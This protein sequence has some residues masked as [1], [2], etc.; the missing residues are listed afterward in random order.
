MDFSFFVLFFCSLD[1]AVVFLCT[2]AEVCLAEVCAEVCVVVC[3]AET[4]SLLVLDWDSLGFW[5]V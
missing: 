3:V 2:F 5:A 1:S 4:D